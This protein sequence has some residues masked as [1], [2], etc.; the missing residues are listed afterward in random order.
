MEIT[1]GND[2]AQRLAFTILLTKK[3][4]QQKANRKNSFSFSNST[5][6]V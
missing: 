3:L 6:T 4:S 1:Q 2:K 5:T